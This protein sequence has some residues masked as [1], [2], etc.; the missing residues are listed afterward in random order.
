LWLA[1]RYGN[2]SVAGILGVVW[3]LGRA[4]Y[5]F[6]YAHDPVRRGMPFGVGMLM[7]AILLVL[8]AIGAIRAML[9]QA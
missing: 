8:G 3:L 5:G 9:L 1:A 4:W 6:A 2:P 7:T